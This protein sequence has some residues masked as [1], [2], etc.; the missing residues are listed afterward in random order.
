LSVPAAGQGEVWDADLDPVEGHEQAGSRPCLII[1]VD[2]VGKGPGE[3][4]IV[5]PVSRLNFIPSLNVEITPPEGGLTD[6][7]Y[8]MPYQV[9]TIS[10]SRLTR[11]RGW[12][13]DATL[14]DVIRR[15]R[16]LIKEP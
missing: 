2:Q 3:L 16:I 1:S 14:T 4:A 12:V 13:Q 5:V 9:R 10:R 7:S 6:V 11:R 15:V 8:A